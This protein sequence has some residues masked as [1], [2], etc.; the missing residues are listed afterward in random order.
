MLHGQYDKGKQ[1]KQLFTLDKAL[2]H[3]LYWK[4]ALI[5]VKPMAAGFYPIQNM[6]LVG[7]RYIKTCPN[8]CRV[9]RRPLPGTRTQQRCSE[10]EAH[11]LW[12]LGQVSRMEKGLSAFPCFAVAIT[13]AIALRHLKTRK[14]LWP[15]P[16]PIQEITKGCVT[17]CGLAI[18][19]LKYLKA[20]EELWELKYFIMQ[21]CNLQKKPLK[22]T[23]ILQDIIT[24]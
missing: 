9:F 8:F 15:Y 24:L 1:S 14:G 7:T 3:G 18:Y 12:K 23:K 5:P 2:S 6:L 13:C 10:V 20:K 11:G 19:I 16:S 22:E 21:K 17:H 4:R